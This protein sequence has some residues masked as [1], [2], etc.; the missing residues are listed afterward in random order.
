MTR[1][2]EGMANK[3]CDF[4]NEAPAVHLEPIENGPGF[5]LTLENNDLEGNSLGSDDYCSH[6]CWELDIHVENEKAKD[7]LDQERLKTGRTDKS[8]ARNSADDILTNR[9]TD[10]LSQE[11]THE[12][13]D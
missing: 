12:K 9:K 1:E 6:E 11:D 4:C 10:N 5:G 3:V 13:L 8:G 7:D 2:V